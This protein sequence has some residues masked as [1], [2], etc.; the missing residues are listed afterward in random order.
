[1]KPTNH[2]VPQL[3]LKIKQE[4]IDSANRESPSTCV[5]AQAL[6]LQ[7]G[8]SSVVVTAESIRFNKEGTDM[9]GQKRM[10][11]Y[12][13][14]TPAKAALH[15]INFDKGKNIEPFEF[16]LYAKEAFASVVVPA[17]PNK[18]RKAGQKNRKVTKP[19]ARICKRRFH[20]IKLPVAV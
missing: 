20:G 15:V 17:G 6:R 18:P 14:V 1:M 10:M 11:R 4:H 2:P 8:A 9:T 12:R 5:I 13:Y 16:R 19:S 3:T 7:H